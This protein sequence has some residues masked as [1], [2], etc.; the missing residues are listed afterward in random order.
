[1][2]LFTGLSLGNEVCGK[3]EAALD[4]LRATADLNWSPTEN[5]HITTKFIGE[6]PAA[7]LPDIQ[8]ALAAL[9]PPGPFSV[10]VSR[11]GFYPTPHRPR[12]LFAGVQAG[13]ELNELARRLDE[14]LA[15]VGCA[16]EERPYL[17]HVTLARIKAEDIRQLRERIALIVN[18]NN[19]DF[20]SFEA[21][22]FHL[23]RSERTPRG[24]VYTKVSGYSLVRPA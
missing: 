13:P 8:H 11:F 10:A 16:R 22:E 20:G 4:E 15:A 2:R 6:W 7:A 1:M 5:L 9:E 21:L 24:P 14:A 23:Y 12:F 17:P 3:I 18:M 19:F